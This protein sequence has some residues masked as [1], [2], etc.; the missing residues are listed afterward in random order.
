MIPPDT[1]ERI[2]EA[3]RIE[4][5]VGDFVS[6]KKRG[7]SL[8]GLCPFHKEKTPSF[9]VSSARGFYKCFGCGKSGTPVTF[10]MEMESLTYPEA[11]R[12]L[13]KKYNIEIVEKEITEE[14]RSA[15]NEKETLYIVSSFA[16]KYFSDLLFNSDEGKSVGLGYFKER[17]FTEETIQKFQLGYAS[18]G[19]KDF[20]LAALKNGYLSEN[21]AKSGLS[22]LPEKYNEADSKQKEEQIFDRYSGRVIFPIQNLNGRVCGF[23]GRILG[24]DKKTAKYIN[25]PQSSIYDKSR[26]LYGLYA[27]RKKILQDDHCYLVE[28]YT[29]VISLHQSGIENVVSSSGT[30]LTPEQIRL[31]HRFTQN[32]TILYDGDLAGI[33]ASFRG[34]N[35]LLEEGMN[36]KVLLFPDGHDPD[37]Y[38]KTVSQEELQNYIREN[39][40][41]FIRFKTKILLQDVANDPI[42]KANLIH[43][44]VESIS[45]VPDLFTR[46]GY[47][48]SCSHLLSIDE[49]TLLFQI[50]AKQ[51]KKPLFV[52]KEIPAAALDN[53]EES[54]A[55]TETLPDESDKALESEIFPYRQQEKNLVRLLLL[56]GLKSI[57]TEVAEEEE[58]V[59]KEIPVA[60]YIL[61]ELSQDEI[62][63]D[64]ANY[65]LFLY[66]YAMGIKAG[67]IPDM[68]FFT[69]HANKRIS[70][71]TIDLLATPYTLSK[72]WLEKHGI[73][74][75]SEEES[76]K[77]SVDHDLNIYRDKRLQGMIREEKEKLRN[78]MNEEETENVLKK[79]KA[80]EKMKM[81]VNKI[82]GRTIVR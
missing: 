13:A 29:D 44:I 10:M 36:V 57:T 54:A 70:E 46:N 3:A 64:D 19:R 73:M 75:M 38:S 40:A 80:L 48:T 21:L 59:L 39:S 55:A 52:S 58:T 49:Q 31:I 7:A 43:E 76:I 14:E 66:E 28:G 12:Y 61:N 81:D 47:V 24:N 82:L 17:G 20:S 4:E 60:V 26:V 16:Q 53:K 1:V 6:L 50:K 35:L 71:L 25:S 74:V 27:S 62:S 8:L 30:S 63:F 67:N 37:S 18:E 33:K 78:V 23:G 79:V 32:I 5:V 56:H 77:K 2:K 22:I 15:Q 9:N 45:L 41:D 11:L 72:R 51:K 69:R 68:D 34:I 65:Q 42:G